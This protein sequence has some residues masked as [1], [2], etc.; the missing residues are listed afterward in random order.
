MNIFNSKTRQDNPAIQNINRL[1]C[2]LGDVN[3][4]PPSLEKL[5]EMFEEI[6]EDDIY[7]EEVLPISLGK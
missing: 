4:T 6:V 1:R 5:A 3:D 7:V 2:A